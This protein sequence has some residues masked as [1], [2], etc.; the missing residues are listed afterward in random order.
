M[1]QRV[2]IT[3]GGGF[4]GKNLVEY[5]ENKY[6]VLAPT[7]Q[8]LDLCNEEQVRKYLTDMRPNILIHTANWGARDENNF[9][10]RDTFYYGLRMFYNLKKCN[11]LYTRMYYFGSG[12]EYDREHYVPFMTEDYYGKYIPKDQYGFYKY[13]LSSECMKKENIYDLRLFGVY[14]KYEQYRYRFISNNICRAIKGLPMTL[15]RNMFFDYL[16]VM[17]LCEI[18]DWFINNKP[19]H[20]HYNVCRG[21]HIDLR[22]IGE[23]IQ[24]KLGI[25][26]EFIIAEEGYKPEYSGN[27]KRLLSEIGNFNFTPIENGIYE[28]YSYYKDI[29]NLIDAETL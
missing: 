25:S 12:A 26:C 4:I 15:S 2:M 17:D 20:H 5:F 29:L 10:L 28:L 3:G 18:M 24:E 21:E 16:Y 11:D 8:E 14:G 1:K 13:I 9:D 6:T 22:T 7:K 23:I 19:K 27:N